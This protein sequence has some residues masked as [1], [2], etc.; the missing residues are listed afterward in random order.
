M[1]QNKSALIP[2]KKFGFS[3]IFSW[4]K[5]KSFE[6]FRGV[7][8]DKVKDFLKANASWISQKLFLQILQN[9]LNW[10]HFKTTEKLA[11]N[12]NCPAEFRPICNKVQFVNSF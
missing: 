12:K 5:M 11:E 9:I 4:L 7:Y 2:P 8:F 10:F 1:Q 6:T 3:L